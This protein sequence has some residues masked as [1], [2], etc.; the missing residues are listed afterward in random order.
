MK[1]PANKKVPVS[2]GIMAYNEERNIGKILKSLINQTENKIKIAEIVVVSSACKDKTDE[3]VK[4]F[5]KLDKRVKLIAQK[6]R[7]GKVRAINDYL[8]RTKYPIIV[9]ESA[10]TLP[11]KNAIEEI[12]KP[13][14]EDES[15]AVVGARPIPT[16]NKNTLMGFISHIQWEL[17]H[18]ASLIK[19]KCGEMLAMRNELD[20]IPPELIIDDAF[21]EL[22]FENKG[23]KVAYAPSSIVL[24]SGPMTVKDF[25]KRRRNLATGFIQLKDKY[26][27][28]PSTS[29]KRWLIKE[30]FRITKANPKKC[31]WS[32][33]GFILNNYAN[34]LGAYD[35][36]VKKK[37]NPVWDMAK[38]TKTLGPVKGR[39]RRS[40]V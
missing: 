14:I 37:C 12:C 24:N 18:R 11:K 1:K 28:E 20:E 31:L 19:P 26:G 30:T 15:V 29:Q 16:N 3:I 36:K 9:M 17:H 4:K 40:H 2:I 10:D 5:S 8:K 34:L 38:S 21:I 32:T 27:Y 23:Q 39:Y 22:F 33:I 6:T 35:Y 7:N 25:I 13:L